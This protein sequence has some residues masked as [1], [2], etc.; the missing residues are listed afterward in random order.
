MT[1]RRSFPVSSICLIAIFL[2]SCS[3]KDPPIFP[4][5]NDPFL[6]GLRF[7]FLSWVRSP[8]RAVLRPRVSSPS[9]H[10]T[11]FVLRQCHGVNDFC[12]LFWMNKREFVDRERK[13]ILMADRD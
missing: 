9:Q 3:L 12:L 1:L 8:Q 11:L 13:H 2:L 10:W 5:H 6:F 7:Y 4:A